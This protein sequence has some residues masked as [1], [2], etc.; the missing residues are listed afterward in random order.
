MPYYLRARAGKQRHPGCSVYVPSNGHHPGRRVPDHTAPT[1]A[2]VCEL[3]NHSNKPRYV[4]PRFWNNTGLVA[5]SR[6]R[7]GGHGRRVTSSVGPGTMGS[8]LSPQAS[9]ISRENELQHG[10]SPSTMLPWFLFARLVY[11][12]TATDQQE[13]PLPGC[14]GRC[15][16]VAVIRDST[17]DESGPMI[18]AL[19]HPRLHMHSTNAVNTDHHLIRSSDGE[20][21]ARVPSF[22]P[23]RTRHTCTFQPRGGQHVDT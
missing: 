15:E 12:H 11:F 14:K 18:S 9:K 23:Q 13:C 19:W 2:P 5:G 21:A 10:A 7:H 20:S 3:Q 17:V 4:Q 16:H 22:I 6:E 8:I 1:Q